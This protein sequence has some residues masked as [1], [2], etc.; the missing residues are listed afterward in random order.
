MVPPLS[1]LRRLCSCDGVTYL[2]DVTIAKERA[3]ASLWSYF[4]DRPDTNDEPLG[5]DEEMESNGGVVW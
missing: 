3:M 4:Q 5:E 2:F 1:A